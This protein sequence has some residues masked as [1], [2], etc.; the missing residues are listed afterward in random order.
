MVKGRD[1]P[2]EMGKGLVGFGHLDGVFTLG[3]RFTFTPVGGH[4]LIGEAK[5]HGAAGLAAG[6]GNDPANGQT[7]LA[8]ICLEAFGTG[9][10]FSSHVSPF[11][12][13]NCK[14]ARAA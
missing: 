14:T 4:E 13:L 10:T 8:G 12:L 5:E 7:L 6:G 3:H 11:S 2:G 1:L 9:G